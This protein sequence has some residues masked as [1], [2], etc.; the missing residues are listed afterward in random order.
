MR[1]Q[2]YGNVWQPRW[3]SV[4]TDNSEQDSDCPGQDSTVG[5]ARDFKRNYDDM[6][7]ANTIGADKY[8]HCKANCEATKRGPSGEASAEAISDAREATDQQ[9]GGT[10]ED[11]AADQEANRTGREGAKENPEQSCRA[12]CD[13]YRPEGLDEEYSAS[14]LVGHIGC[15]RC[16]CCVSRTP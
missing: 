13:E 7:D 10:A 4:E 3:E 8:F 16:I 12:T 5:A 11:S 9:R 2:R 1:H 15:Y 6:R 14:N